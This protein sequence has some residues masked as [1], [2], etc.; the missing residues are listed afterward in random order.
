MGDVEY[1]PNTKIIDKFERMTQEYQRKLP[2]QTDKL[3]INKSVL[4]LCMVP[5]Y[6]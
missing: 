5:L 6:Y 2:Q 4:F 3:H 1:R